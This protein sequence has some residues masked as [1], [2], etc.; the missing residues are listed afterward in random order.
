MHVT[1]A[2]LACLLDSV[3]SHGIFWNPT[4]RA[5]LAQLSGWESDATSIISEPMPEVA[6]GRE[7]PGGRPWAE[8]G[9]SVSNVGPCGMK[10][11]GQKTNWNHP[12]HGWGPVQAT[13]K[14]GGVIDVSWCVSDLADHGGVY[15]YRICTDPKIT[16]TFIDSSYTPDER[17]MAELEDCFQKGILACTCSWPKVPSASGLQGWMGLHELKRVVQ[18]WSEGWWPLPLAWTREVLDT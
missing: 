2:L 3:V 7:Y 10:A 13:L 12:E 15:S 6:H 18:L 17:D 8:P 4:S 5:Q 9:K 14:A 11:Y 1:H 16:A